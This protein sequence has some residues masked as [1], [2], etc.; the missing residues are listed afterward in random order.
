VR[1]AAL[2]LIISLKSAHEALAENRLLFHRRMLSLV[3]GR[4]WNDLDVNSN[5]K[6]RDRREHRKPWRCQ[7]YDAPGYGRR[8]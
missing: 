3:R 7:G 2:G 6:R 5:H 8:R 4:V 1:L